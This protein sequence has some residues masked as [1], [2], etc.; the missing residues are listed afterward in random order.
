MNNV[1]DYS[2]MVMVVIDN[3]TNLVIP[4]IVFKSWHP[5]L[6]LCMAFPGDQISACIM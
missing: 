4:H 6:F 5:D 1:A 2:V 3:I